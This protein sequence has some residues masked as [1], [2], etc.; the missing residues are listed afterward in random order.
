MYP[1]FSVRYFCLL[2]GRSRQGWYELV[3]CKSD[4]QM[5]AAL[6]LKLVKEI[7]EQLPRAG[8]PKLQILLKGKLQEHEIK[9]GRNALYR[10]LGERMQIRISMTENGDP[11]ENAIAE[12]LNGILKEEF[13]LHKTFESFEDALPAVHNAIEKY[14]HIRPHAGCD[15]LTPVMAH[16]RAGALRKRWKPKQHQ[17]AVELI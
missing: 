4:Q 5:A 13:L 10:L 11:Y 14:N 3:K 12:R 9:M 1:Q 15:N 7:R 16:E 17:T 6:V 8:V 2:F